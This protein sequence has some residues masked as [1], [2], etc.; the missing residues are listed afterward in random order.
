[1]FVSEKRLD[2]MIEGMEP[3]AK[4]KFGIKFNEFSSKELYECL[5]ELKSV[6]QAIKDQK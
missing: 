2:E 5:C 3:Y 1:V 6:R 4:A